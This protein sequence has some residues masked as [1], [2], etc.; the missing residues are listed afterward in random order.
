M[1]ERVRGLRGATTVAHDDADAI[2][3]ATADL[4]QEMLERN[5]VA[6]DDLVSL[7]FTSTS[8][9]TAEF[10]AAAAR[11]LGIDHIPLLCAREIDVPGSVPRCIRVL[12]H[13]YTGRDHGTLRHV[14]LR[15]ARRLRSD[16]PE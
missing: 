1:T 10:P 11:R 5:E 16:L 6:P 14:Y 9:L 8:D 2:V 13:L 15:G 7:V 3:A 4:L 12:M